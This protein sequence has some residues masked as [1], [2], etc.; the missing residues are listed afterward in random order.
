MDDVLIGTSV[1]ATVE[2]G[3]AL[4]LQPARAPWTLSVAPGVGGRAQ[5]EVSVT[6]DA[7]RGDAAADAVWHALDELGN[8]KR[9]YTFAGPV[10]LIR[11]TAD[12][13]PAVLELVA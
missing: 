5:V 8:E 13:A 6:P 4:L 12:A 10:T 7:Q 9:L 3:A 2:A 1:R 11:V